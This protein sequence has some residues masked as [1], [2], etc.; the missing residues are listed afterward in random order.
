M[1]LPPNHFASEA[2][3]APVGRRSARLRRPSVR[4]TAVFFGTPADGDGDRSGP[5]HP[6]RFSAV[7]FGKP[8][9]LRVVALESNR[10]Q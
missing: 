4:F 1:V 3:F 10:P 5:A 6:V 7:V 9:R 2:D 8:A